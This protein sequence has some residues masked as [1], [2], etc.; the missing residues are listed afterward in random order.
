[1]CPLSA[2]RCSALFSLWKAESADHGSQLAHLPVDLHATKQGMR[3]AF[4]GAL[5]RAA[6][7]NPDNFS[8]KIW[9]LKRTA[10]YGSDHYNERPLRVIAAALSADG[11][12]VRL[13]IPKIEPTWCMEIRY[14]LKTADGEAV[15]S[16][17]HNTIHQLGSPL[18][19]A[20]QPRAG[21]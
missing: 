18:A 19:P 16:V 8:V 7:E 14:R 5:D 20:L 11:K 9:G 6:A 15:N 12:T 4:S 17:I 1:M 21:E 10:N 3:I 2:N 13:E